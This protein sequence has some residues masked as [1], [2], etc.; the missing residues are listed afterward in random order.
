MTK[1]K[2]LRKVICVI[3]QP[4]TNMEIM[5]LRYIED[6]AIATTLFLCYSIEIGPTVHFVYGLRGDGLN[7]GNLFINQNFH[8]IVTNLKNNQRPDYMLPMKYVVVPAHPYV[9][10]HH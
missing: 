7:L 2:E 4:H 6:N 5:C 1:C 10:A 8:I 3:S 9:L